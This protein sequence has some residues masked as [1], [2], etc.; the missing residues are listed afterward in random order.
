MHDFDGITEDEKYKRIY[1]EYASEREKREEQLHSKQKKE[2]L[3]KIGM[4]AVEVNGRV[5][6]RFEHERAALWLLSWLNE[7]K[8]SFASYCVF[9]NGRKDLDK[10]HHG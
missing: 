2:M 9:Y 3:E 7:S 10:K 6:V 1:R 8:D 5:V 4:Q